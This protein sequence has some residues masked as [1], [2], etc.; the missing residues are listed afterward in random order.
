[1]E[2]R[3][4][5]KSS[6]EMSSTGIAS[7]S[8]MALA[9]NARGIDR[10]VARE[11]RERVAVAA[12]ARLPRRRPRDQREQRRRQRAARRW[13]AISSPIS[14]DDA[15]EQDVLGQH[16]DEDVDQFIARS[17]RVR[18]GARS[19]R[20]PRD[21][22]AFNVA[23]R[24]ASRCGRR[25]PAAGIAAPRARS[26]SRAR[27]ERARAR[28][29][30]P[31]C[32]ARMSLFAQAEVDERLVRRLRRAEQEALRERQHVQRAQHDAGDGDLR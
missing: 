5:A 24:C 19:A 14:D 10:E 22:R 2:L 8:T 27:R 18:C 9:S 21:D 30:R 3:A 25:R 32:D 17:R 7:A 11:R 12:R 23:A 6:R 28:T 20:R 26:C 29:R 31:R 4:R 1:M 13:R 15:R 16:R